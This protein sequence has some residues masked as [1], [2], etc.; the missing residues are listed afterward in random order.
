MAVRLVDNLDVP[1]VEKLV[2][3]KAGKMVSIMVVTT[4][5]LMVAMMAF[6]KVWLQA[7]K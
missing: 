7:V 3:M 5:M 1:M 6:G 2:V 4:D